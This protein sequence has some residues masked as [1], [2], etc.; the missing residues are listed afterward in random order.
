MA[1]ITLNADQVAKNLWI[2]GVPTD[3]DEVDKQFDALVLA[4]KEFQTVFPAHKYPKT[5]VI[6]APL[7]DGNPSRG[8]IIDALRAALDVYEHNKAGRKVLVTCAKGV[9]RS[10]LIA[11]MAMVISG[12]KPNEAIGMIRKHRHPISGAQPLFNDHFVRLIKELDDLLTLDNP[13]R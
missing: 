8:E 13:T 3:P 7:E 4:A 5:H 11:A 2:G 1:A 6:Y 9:N 10:S 12:K